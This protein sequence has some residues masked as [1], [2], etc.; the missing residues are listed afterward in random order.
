M[1]YAGSSFT[2]ANPGYRG[3]A[4]VWLTD[5]YPTYA[6]TA[7]VQAINGHNTYSA[8]VRL[9]TGADVFV[10]DNANDSND[11]VNTPDRK[12]LEALFRRLW[13]ANP[14]TRIIVIGPPSWF[15]QDT[16]DNA[17]VDTPTNQTALEEIKALA[18]HY[19]IAYVDYWQWC[20]DVV[21]DT[22]DLTDLTADTV[23]PT[24]LGYNQM[25]TLLE[26]YL[27]TS[28]SQKPATLPARLYDN[29]DYENTPTRTLG[30]NYDSRTGTGW[31]DSGTATLSAT[32][33][34]TIT[35]SAT[36]QSIGVYRSAGTNANLE[37]SVDG[38]AYRDASLTQN[39]IELVEGR[40]AH[41]ITI[42]LK[43]GGDI[44]ID[45]FWAI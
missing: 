42:R 38:G 44:R 19:G 10:I 3:L 20:R 13:A 27:P 1:A 15:G 45:E 21:P 37:I 18:D 34:D 36:C 28:G 14:Q 32:A 29:G 39:G 5:N 30:T 24:D 2:A 41:T 26:A 22:Y 31:S 4:Q 11:S 33:G 23:H 16:S 7:T 35:Y 43:A 9:E 6:T 12:A 25:A 17:V 8:L 40:D